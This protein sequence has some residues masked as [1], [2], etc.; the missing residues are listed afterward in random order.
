MGCACRKA[1]NLLRHVV[2][3]YPAGAAAVCQQGALPRAAQLLS[4]A[5]EDTWQAALALL[6]ELSQDPSAFKLMQQVSLASLG[7]CLHV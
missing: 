3:G 1:L 2:H 5:D 6:Q 4:S 7:P